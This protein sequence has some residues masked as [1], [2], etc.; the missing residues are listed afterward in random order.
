MAMKQEI[1][2]CHIFLAKDR[3]RAQHWLSVG[4]GTNLCFS[5]KHH[6]C[7]VNPK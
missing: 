3:Y 5:P 7:V 2:F 1:R 6:V 4:I